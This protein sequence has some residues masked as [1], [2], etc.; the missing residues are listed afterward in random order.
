MI[1]EHPSYDFEKDDY[2]IVVSADCDPFWLAKV[3]EIT[4]EQ[5]SFKYFHHNTPKNG[6]KMT[7][8]LHHTSG[9]CGILDVYIKFKSEFDLF[10]KSKSIRTTALRK[11]TQSCL[12]YNGQVVPDGFK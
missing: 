7:W 2:I 1:S 11:I 10:T 5:L 12:K 3:T 8:K 6:N 9:N 4:N